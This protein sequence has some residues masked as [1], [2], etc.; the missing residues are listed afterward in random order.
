MS[1]GII[2]AN[3]YNLDKQSLINDILQHD[4]YSVNATFT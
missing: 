4:G 2:K 3:T 1:A